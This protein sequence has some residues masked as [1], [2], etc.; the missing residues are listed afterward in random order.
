MMTIVAMRLHDASDIT[1]AISQ[2]YYV[3]AKAI[4]ITNIQ[5][6]KDFENNSI[7][8]KGDFIGI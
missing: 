7:Y 4:K 6:G 1:S 2:K 8:Q 3:L 5:S